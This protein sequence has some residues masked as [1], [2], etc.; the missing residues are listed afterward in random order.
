MV[1]T[2]TSPR[3]AR[4]APSVTGEEPEPLL[5]P[6]P[7]H[8]NITG[9]LRP[10]LIAGVQMFSTRQSSLSLG[11]P[12]AATAIGDTDRFAP[13]CICGALGPYAIASR[14]PAHFAGA[15]GGMKRFL[16]AVL[17]PYGMPLNTLIPFASTP[18][19][20]PSAVS[21][22]TESP[23]AANTRVRPA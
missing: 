18:R 4:L 12:A 7:W 2:T 23:S 13:G 11:R 14:T 16:P 22:T 9:R 3:R 15:T 19:T 10:S 5:K 21:A 17:A 6:P 8:Q 20:R 1:T